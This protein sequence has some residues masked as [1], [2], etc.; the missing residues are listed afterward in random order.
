MDAGWQGLP[1]RVRLPWLE[2]C[3]DNE[4]T[5]DGHDQVESSRAIR[6]HASGLDREGI[7]FNRARRFAIHSTLDR[8][9][10]L[11]DI[12][13]IRSEDAPANAPVKPAAPLRR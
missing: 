12:V 8:R 1:R 11:A 10:S 9:G 4:K 6:T 7:L 13:A 5:D 2:D 3:G